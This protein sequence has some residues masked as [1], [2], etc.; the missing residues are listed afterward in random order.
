MGRLGR[1]DGWLVQYILGYV[2]MDWDRP[3]RTQLRFNMVTWLK[4]TGKLGYTSKIIQVCGAD[5]GSVRE[6]V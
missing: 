6:D 3:D 4:T 5:G 2:G 1:L